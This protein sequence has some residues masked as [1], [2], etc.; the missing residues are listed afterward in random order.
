LWPEAIFAYVLDVEA[1]SLFD[2]GRIVGKAVIV[3]TS[4][5]MA[6]S[7]VR[8]LP[9][10]IAGPLRATSP[11]F[12]VLGAILLFDE[13]PSLAQWSGMAVIFAGYVGFAWLGPKEGIHF[14]ANR[15]V[16]LLVG[17]TL[18]GAM[19]GLYDKYLLQGTTLRPTTLQF[20]F[21]AYNAVLQ[22]I[23]VWFWW[24]PKRNV[25]PFRFRPNAVWVGLFL[26]LADQLYFRALAIP[27]ALVSVVS[28]TRRTSVL[29]SFTVGGVLFREQLLRQ[30]SLAL[31][32]IVA[33]LLILLF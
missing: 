23:L 17:G 26:L 7:A 6:Y 29:I 22:A 3:T 14:R 15:W 33:G 5:V 31:A 24:W 10:S 1:I 27:D 2:H 30:K 20:W 25:A 13:S 18:V 19:S 4:W 32:L 12:T 9:I 21:T 28:L 11:I 16:A 8:H